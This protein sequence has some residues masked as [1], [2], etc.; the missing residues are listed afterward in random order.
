MTFLCW[1]FIESCAVW[2]ANNAFSRGHQ[3]QLIRGAVGLHAKLKMATLIFLLSLSDFQQIIRETIPFAWAFDGENSI[4]E[5]WFDNPN[6]RWF[7]IVWRNVL[8]SVYSF[9]AIY[10]FY[11]YY[12]IP[13]SDRAR[14][15]NV[16]EL[17]LAKLL[18]IAQITLYV[19]DL[20]VKI[21]AQR[22]GVTLSPELLLRLRRIRRNTRRD[23]EP[24]QQQHSSLPLAQS[25]QLQT[26]KLEIPSEWCQRAVDEVP[27]Q[28]HNGSIAIEKPHP[29]Y[30]RI[31]LKQ[32][33][34]YTK[35]QARFRNRPEPCS[36]IPPES[37]RKLV[38]PIKLISFSELREVRSEDC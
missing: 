17:R 24:P 18:T 36:D 13:P 30:F 29:S 15:E 38:G 33:A 3:L 23:P 8:N 32:E 31:N 21:L 28:T 10:A 37:E 20:I 34:H 25:S 9:G 27:V 26:V 5:N 14:F 16:L 19:S 1:M 35:S 11:N 2:V 4:R 7:S 12:E 22:Y 6:P